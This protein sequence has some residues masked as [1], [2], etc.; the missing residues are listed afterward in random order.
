MS[1]IIKENLIYT[2]EKNIGKVVTIKKLSGGLTNNIYLINDNYIWKNFKDTTFLDHKNEKIV[3]Q[4]LENLTLYYSDDHNLC[5]NFIKGINIDK[6]FYQQN[7]N[8]VINL[9]KKYN[10]NKIKTEHFWEQVLK[11]WIF[12]IPQCNFVSKIELF[13]YY[14]MINNKL[15]EFVNLDNDNVLCHHDIHSANVII[16]DGKLSLIDLEFSYTDYNF[17][18]LGNIIC[19]LNTDYENQIYSYQNSRTI[20]KEIILQQYYGSVNDTNKLKLEI[21]ILI[22]HLYW[23]IWGIYM[24]KINGSENFDYL[25]F[26]KSRI[27]SLKDSLIYLL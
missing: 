9:T 2:F 19:E 17:I 12:N 25:K 22:S 27:N 13:K 23:C 1:D 7:I 10:Q 14:Y 26:S 16:S 21:G 11:K 3:I 8:K 24:N 15:A 5:Y 18:E 6:N 4:N 20:E